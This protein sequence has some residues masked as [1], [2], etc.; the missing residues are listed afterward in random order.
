MKKLLL[1]IILLI[2]LT[3]CVPSS[4]TETDTDSDSAEN[5]D[6]T[7]N[8]G[9]TDEV[10]SENLH[11]FTFI[12]RTEIINDLT[13]DPVGSDTGRADSMLARYKAVEDR[14]T[15]IINTGT[16]P[17]NSSLTE[18]KS[19]SAAT[20]KFADIVETTFANVY[21][22]HHSNLIISPEDVPN[23]DLTT[24]KW[25][26]PSIF[27]ATTFTD[28]K[29][30]G[31][32]PLYWGITPPT[33]SNVMFYNQNLLKTF[34]LPDPGELYETNLWSWHNFNEIALA[35]TQKI[36]DD[37]SIHAFSEPNDK[38]P[39]FLSAA[40]TSNGGKYISKDYK[41]DWKFSL[42][43]QNS[44]DA[45]EWVRNMVSNQKL[46]YRVSENHESNILDI[47]AFVNLKTVFL[48]TDSYAGMTMNEEYLL[49]TFD[50]NFRWISFPYGP[51]WEGKKSS[52]AIFSLNDQFAVMTTNFDTEKSFK[53]MD[54][55][56][57][58]LE[59]EDINSWKT[60]LKRNYFFYDEDFSTYFNL[61]K[62]AQSNDL[63][64]L[65]SSNNKINSTL[66]DLLTGISVP[67]QAFELIEGI[68]LTGITE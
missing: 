37:E 6:I 68:V 39:A 8:G 43:E 57:E 11:N 59:D 65:Q 60:Y 10:V 33:I 40:I 9:D 21:N 2:S 53:I 62:D 50:E 45:I 19:S 25:G 18:L 17:A 66:N 13:L 26:L 61:L 20:S 67:S 41:N 55:I 49:S 44:V 14:Y 22:L 46:A 35:L 47:L 56:F 54:A 28:G 31:F 63:I 23:M 30:Y 42:K 34:D 32:K 51:K 48:V 38:Y 16:V 24:E 15:C 29:P 27:A 36:A 12:I 64:R 58:P 5:N 1:L 52:I 7:L 4:N 3:A